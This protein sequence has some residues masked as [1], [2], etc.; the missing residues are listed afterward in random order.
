MH[1]DHLQTRLPKM[2]Q[3]A[4]LVWHLLTK[5]FH[6]HGPLIGGKANTSEAYPD[7]FVELICEGVRKE[8]DDAN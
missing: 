4:L 2:M 7:Q 3:P 5:Q 6:K 8:L 1:Q